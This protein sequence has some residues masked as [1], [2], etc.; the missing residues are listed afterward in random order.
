MSENEI[1]TYQAWINDLQRDMDQLR[2]DKRELLR[3]VAQLEQIVADY[4]TKINNLIQHR[5]DE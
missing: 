4:G 5:G 3:K 1:I 2:D